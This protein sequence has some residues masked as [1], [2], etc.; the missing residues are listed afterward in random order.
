MAK[1]LMPTI[2][3]CKGNTKP[4]LAEKEEDIKLQSK[5]C[6]C[7]VAGAINKLK[8]TSFEFFSLIPLPKQNS[9]R[10]TSND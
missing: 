5:D 6:L 4:A 1:L 7:F 8:K 9:V 2:E 10:F 3:V